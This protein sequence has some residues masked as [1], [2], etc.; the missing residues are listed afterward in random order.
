MVLNKAWVDASW[1][2]AC[3]LYDDL[4]LPGVAYLKKRVNYFRSKT[5]AIMFFC[6]KPTSPDERNILKGYGKTLAKKMNYLAKD[7]S[8]HFKVFSGDSTS[9][10][11][12]TI[13]VLSPSVA[14]V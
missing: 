2:K 13:S 14:R 10:T 9:T 5:G 6:K 4:E 12:L 8:F 1:K 3:T 7:G 11:T